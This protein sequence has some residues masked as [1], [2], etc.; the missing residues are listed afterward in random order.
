MFTLILDSSNIDLSVGLAKDKELIDVVNYEAWQCQSEYMTLEI[1]KML[2]K[3]HLS[4]DDIKDVIVTI[5]PGS[6]TGL[7]IALTIAKVMSLALNIPLYALSSLHVLKCGDKPSI[8]LLNARS[9]R[10]YIGVYEKGNVILKDT[11]LKNDEVKEYI[12]NHPDY[13]VCGDTS[14]LGIDGYK[15]N[16]CLE[17]LSL[18]DVATKYDDS[19]GVHPLYLKD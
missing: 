13:V 6:Y 10:S 18:K 7:R 8:C 17:M 4:K 3:H 5:G 12:D 15:A 2:N 16:I 1:D 19:L 11:I 9:N 14:Y